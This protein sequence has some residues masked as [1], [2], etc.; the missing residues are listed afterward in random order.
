MNVS[1]FKTFSV[2]IVSDFRDV[3]YT[4]VA[5]YMIC[6]ICLFLCYEVSCSVYVVDVPA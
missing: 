1:G 2:G 6:V 4:Y 3:P 5:V